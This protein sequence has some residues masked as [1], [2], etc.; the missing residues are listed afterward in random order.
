MDN[1]RPVRNNREDDDGFDFS[2]VRVASRIFYVSNERKINSLSGNILTVLFL[3]FKHAMFSM[4]IT[5]TIFFKQVQSTEY[6][7]VEH[8]DFCIVAIPKEGCKVKL[9]K[10][11]KKCGALWYYIRDLCYKCI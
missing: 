11:E 1:W 7:S 5:L 10:L 3:A 2:G 4:K 9:Q 8:V 6:K